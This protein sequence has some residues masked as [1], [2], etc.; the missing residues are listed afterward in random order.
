M[1]HKSTAGATKNVLTLMISVALIGGGVTGC[2]KTK[3]A[4]TLI[5]DAKQYQQKGDDKAAII[6]L[7]NALQK[8]RRSAISREGTSQ[9]LKPGD[10]SRQGIA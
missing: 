10:E 9:G 8:N 2:E 4:Q 3:D 5:A 6:Q 1:R 7:K